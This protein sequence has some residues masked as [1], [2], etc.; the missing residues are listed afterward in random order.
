MSNTRKTLKSWL[1]TVVII[2]SALVLYLGTVVIT[3]AFGGT[4]VVVAIISNAVLFVAG[5]FWLRSRWQR[6]NSVVPVRKRGDHALGSRFWAF[7]V[8]T[9]L[10]CWLV[11][12]AS[13]AW[14]YSLTGSSNF[15]AHVA[16]E[17]RA[18]LVLMLVVVLVLAPM[19]EEMLMRGIAYPQLR[20]H[21]PP[22]AAA[23]V[24]AG[25]FSLMHLNLVQIAVTLPLG[26]LLA[27]VYERT[28]R[29][30]PVVLLHVLFNLMSAV[31]PVG[32]VLGFASLTFVMLG[33]VA[34]VLLLAWLYRPVLSAGSEQA[35]NGPG[36]PAEGSWVKS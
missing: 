12:Q 3:M 36:E 15:D 17:N 22:L 4:P 5:S 16:A 31:V 11:G 26:F 25:L 8:L 1:P 13:S 10:V 19:G 21:M 29:L 23:A 7:V 2:G 14:I 30:A 28:G 20:K 18:P 33:G 27:L 24:T 9:L 6:A 34:V 32:F 35:L